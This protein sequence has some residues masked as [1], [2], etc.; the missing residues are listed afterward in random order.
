[1]TK[2]NTKQT[3]EIEKVN[4]LCAELR[5]ADAEIALMQSKLTKH[6]K[7]LYDTCGCSLCEFDRKHQLGS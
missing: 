3:N 7:R 5:W 1:M 2:F 4:E 6:R